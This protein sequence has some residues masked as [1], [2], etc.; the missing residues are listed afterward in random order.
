MTTPIRVL[1]VDDDPPV[2]NGMK[3]FL[4]VFDDLDVIATAQDG[5]EAVRLAGELSPDVILIDVNM[6]IMDGIEA[7]RIIHTRYPRIQIIA[8]T[9]HEDIETR[10]LMIQAGASEYLE[11][12]VGV[13]RM[14]D[15][16]RRVMEKAK[17]AV[18][19][20]LPNHS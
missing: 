9:S 12:T 14:A 2:L 17:S 6:P 15:T 20:Q 8:L 7:A 4:R 13:V 1:L 3:T 10:T 5:E 19:E 11:K 16:V 18:S